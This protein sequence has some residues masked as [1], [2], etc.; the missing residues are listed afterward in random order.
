MMC[1]EGPV[2]QL[3]HRKQYVFLKVTVQIQTKLD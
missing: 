1:V 2:P 3:P